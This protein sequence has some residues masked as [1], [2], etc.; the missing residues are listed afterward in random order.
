MD[1][2]DGI[3]DDDDDDKHIGEDDD[4]NDDNDNCSKLI[5]WMHRKA[6]NERDLIRGSP[7]ISIKYYHHHHNFHHL[8]NELV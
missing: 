5:R 3:G 2:Y 1:D 7:T 4:E 8:D 6:G